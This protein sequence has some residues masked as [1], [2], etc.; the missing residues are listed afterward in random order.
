VPRAFSL[1]G[2]VE[3]F[4]GPP[5]SYGARREVLS[6]VA[7]LGMNA[8]VYAPKDDP[9]H[10]A[11]WREPYPADEQ[12]A[13]AQLA[14]HARGLGIRFGFAISPGLD[15]TYESDADRAQLEAKLAP[16]LDAGVDWFVLALDDIP[17]SADLAHRQAEL[18]TWLHDRVCAALP[19]ASI[20]V[21]PTEYVGT[22]PSPYLG[23]L[24]A[25]LPDEISL[26]WTGPTVCSPAITVADASGWTAAVA[27]HD[28]LLWD[29]YPVNDG[30]MTTRLHLGPYEGRDARLADMLGG[31]L[32]NPMSQPHASLV[33]L[34]SAAGFLSD[35]D[36]YD[37]A[38]AWATAVDHVGGEQAPALRTLAAG[39]ADGPL[40]PAADL[41][42][43][44]LVA[45]LDEEADGPGWVGA[46][47][48]VCAVL[49]AARD[50]PA[51]FPAG[52]S[53]DGAAEALSSEVAPWAAAA[54]REA[55]AGLAALRLLQ[56]SRPV[57]RID[58]AGRGLAAGPDADFLLQAVFAL[59]FSWSGARANTEVVYGP[60]FAI[61][62]AVVQTAAGR[63]AVDVDLALVE[64]ANVIDQLCRV[65]LREYEKWRADADETVRAL[66]DGEERPIAADGS[67][68]AR[69]TM[70]LVRSGGLATRVRPGDDLP[71]RDRRLE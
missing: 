40:R 7:P 26:L 27:P 46:A 18:A 28:V 3:G 15:I 33:A 55:E 35:P 39:C 31:V 45:T 70:T 22:L 53:A 12:A 71:V 14:A 69:G 44:G 30:T 32:L 47:R 2:I 68:D 25:G 62:P 36:G 23:D 29:N 38:S 13:L 43:G 10:R 34:A 8:Y 5:W 57:A 56:G 42:L 16:L 24:A 64:D 4:Y 41:E 9:F 49:R 51:A 11:R 65:A 6:F 19:G 59:M 21:C 63:P 52:A 60:R 58:D 1:R 54:A 20:T 50:L 61:Y 67:F 17:A 37:A 48:A 66:V